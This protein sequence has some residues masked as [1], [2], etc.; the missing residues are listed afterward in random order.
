[1]V[2]S[3]ELHTYLYLLCLILINRMVRTKVHEEQTAILMQGYTSD[4]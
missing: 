2:S 4:L 1:M 3:T